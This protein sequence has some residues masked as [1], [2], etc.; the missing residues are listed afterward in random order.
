MKC[1]RCGY[2]CKSYMVVIVDDPDKGIVDDNFKAR[3]G[4]EPCQHLQG[5]TPG[6]YSCAIH[7]YPWYNQTPCFDFTQIEEKN[8]ECRM[9]RFLIDQEALVQC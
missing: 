3:D 7:S 4:K 9:G 1:L 2:C 5:D 6:E 8:S